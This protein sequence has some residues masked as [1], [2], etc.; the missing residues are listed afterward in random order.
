MMFL[1]PLVSIPVVGILDWLIIRRVWRAVNKSPSAPT[2]SVQ[3]PD[4]FW[5]WFALSVFALIAI[6]FLISIVGLLAAIAIPNFVKAR[7]QAKENARHAAQM[8]A[9]NQPA[10]N[11][12][13]FGPVM[14]RVVNAALETKENTAIDLD[15]GKLASFP[16]DLTGDDAEKTKTWATINGVDAYGVYEPQEAT[17]EAAEQREKR[18]Y[19]QNGVHLPPGRLTGL[20]FYDAAVLADS[21]SDWDTITPDRVVSMMAKPSTR[22]WNYAPSKPGSTTTWLF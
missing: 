10:A 22:Q 16:P 5:R 3:K 17:A 20:G 6:P 18:T 8:L 12:L 9:T 2:Q 15:T 19:E 13:S 4:R 1:I 14:E 7:A 11:N 21:Y